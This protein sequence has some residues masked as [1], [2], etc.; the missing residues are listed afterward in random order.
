M[1]RVQDW[2]IYSFWNFMVEDNYLYYFI[3]KNID[4]TL[5]PSMF[6]IRFPRLV[7]TSIAAYSNC[8]DYYDREK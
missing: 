1:G 8:S 3:N 5:G 2:K 4:R 7:L 6:R